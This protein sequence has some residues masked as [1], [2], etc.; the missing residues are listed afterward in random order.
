[1]IFLIFW[2]LIT[3]ILW[4]L[5][6]HHHALE[7]RTY[8]MPFFLSSLSEFLFY[9][10]YFSTNKKR[11]KWPFRPQLH[12][13]KV[14]LSCVFAGTRNRLH[15]SFFVS[16]PS[17]LLESPIHYSMIWNIYINQKREYLAHSFTMIFYHFSFQVCWTFCRLGLMYVELE[18]ALSVILVSY[19]IAYQTLR[20]A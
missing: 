6:I 5:S 2:V 7:V 10:S 14:F 20:T 4:A 9:N 19:K 1:M 3:S 8:L 12:S 13:M 15:K 18:G 11:Y 16:R 17:V